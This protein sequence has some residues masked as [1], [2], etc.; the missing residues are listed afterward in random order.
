MAI[1][2][3]KLPSGVAWWYVPPGY[4]YTAKEK[5]F[6]DAFEAFASRVNNLPDFGWY[7]PVSVTSDVTMGST[8]LIKGKGVDLLR[9]NGSQLNAGDWNF[10]VQVIP[11]LK[12]LWEGVQKAWG[13]LPSERRDGVVNSDLDFK[14][15]YTAVKNS[16]DALSVA[17]NGMVVPSTLNPDWINALVARLDPLQAPGPVF[18]GSVPV[19]LAAL[20]QTLQSL[21]DAYVAF[22]QFASQPPA[23]DVNPAQD[24]VTRGDALYANS[25]QVILQAMAR[26][27]EMDA[28]A[29]VMTAQGTYDTRAAAVDALIM[30]AR[31]FTLTTPL[32]TFNASLASLVEGRAAMVEA[33]EGIR[34]ASQSWYDAHAAKYQSDLA[35]VDQA[36]LAVRQMAQQ[37]QATGGGTQSEAADAYFADVSSDMQ[38]W[39]LE[40]DEA[41]RF[42]AS[43]ASL[44]AKLKATI[45]SY[46]KANVGGKYDGTLSQFAAMQV[47]IEKGIAWADAVIQAL[48]AVISRAQSIIQN[49]DL[50]AARPVRPTVPARPTVPPSVP[51]PLP[52]TVEGTSPSVVTGTVP[53]TRA[54]P[55]S[56]PASGTPAKTVPQSPKSSPMAPLIAATVLLNL[57]S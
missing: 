33:I 55:V 6:V 51:V 57:L 2:A 9:M 28:Q 38:K 31:A 42:R 25:R 17:A 15:A 40:R 4:T 39:I 12:A 48:S 29:L 45:D 10:Y 21:E 8:L 47:D 49:R 26:R 11:N 23:G 16:Y 34:A 35:T 14:N 56:S 13:D 30:Q 41:Y 3:L 54:T 1:P 52:P 7:R 43:D 27:E 46:S 19:S 5:I 24:I 44:L 37:A 18:N 20:Q 50:A 32:A 53:V 36:I 22:K